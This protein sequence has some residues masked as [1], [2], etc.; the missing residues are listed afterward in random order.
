M[1]EDVAELGA[2]AAIALDVARAR[3]LR[4]WSKS[5]VGAAAG[6]GGTQA[7]LGLY[8]TDSCS[9]PA[10]GTQ[11]RLASTFRGMRSASV[12]M[13]TFN[14]E[15]YVG[16]QV[17]SILVQMS[18]NDELVIVDDASTDNTLS[19]IAEFRDQ[20]INLIRRQSNLGHV[21]AFETAIFNATGDVIV[22]SDQDDVWLPKRLDRMRQTLSTSREMV[23]ATGLQTFSADLPETFGEI[24]LSRAG[25]LKDS[26][27]FLSGR[28]AYFG[29]GMAFSSR[30]RPVILPFPPMVIA[31]DHW[32]A[33][34]GF[35]SNGIAQDPEPSVL[36]R[37][38]GANLTP[39]S[40][41]SL[42][43]ALAY[44]VDL[45]K[46]IG[47]ARWRWLKHRPR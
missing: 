32:I 4:R 47:I 44:R 9:D 37:I 30:L 33:V 35:S 24:R 43:V 27:L 26:A 25:R 12:C 39:Q 16:E 14:G 18:A 38:H 1:L 5:V 40:R 34:A 10:G 17:E 42:G 6:L 23:L 2:A 8:P 28:Q 36:R 19:V 41:R 31:H 22:L 45:V 21:K 13:A 15:S 7:R 20:R 29:S 11:S 46:L 3:S